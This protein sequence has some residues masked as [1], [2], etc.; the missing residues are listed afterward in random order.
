MAEPSSDDP[1]VAEWLAH[2]KALAVGIRPRGPTREHGIGA[3][4]GTRGFLV[5]GDGN[6]RSAVSRILLPSRGSRPRCPGS[7]SRTGS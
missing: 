2:V 4:A 5:N 3:F 6:S 1:D 7:S